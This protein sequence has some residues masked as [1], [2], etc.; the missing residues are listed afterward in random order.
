MAE[1]TQGGKSPDGSPTSGMA[2]GVTPA[3]GSGGKKDVSPAS[4]QGQGE[5]QK[6]EEFIPRERFDQVLETARTLEAKIAEMEQRTRQTSGR[7]WADVPET[8]LQ[9]IITHSSD[10]PDHS[11]AALAELRRRDRETLKS[12][13]LG[14]VGISEF[15]TTN[16]DAFDPTSPL[17]KEVNKIMAGGRSQKEILSDVVELAKYRI[18]GA[19]ASADARKKLAQ[20]MQAASVMAPGSDLETKIPPPSFMDMPKEEFNKFKESVML[21]EF[22]KK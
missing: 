17:G 13:I 1:E 15:R 6:R 21:G 2:G 12:E 19:N 14:E 8:D 11:G 10:F 5:A 4:T 20:N 3:E 9:Y 16:S 18:G 22:K 7:T